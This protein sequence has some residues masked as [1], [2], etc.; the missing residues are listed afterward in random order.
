M[1]S[2]VAPRVARICLEYFLYMCVHVLESRR[3]ELGRERN[4]AEIVTSCMVGSATWW[5]D[6][7]EVVSNK[8]EACHIVWS[9]YVRVNTI[10][11][12]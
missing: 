2:S 5:L 1:R 7:S 12:L 9:S 8:A 4:V 6:A 11:V 10:Y 3:F